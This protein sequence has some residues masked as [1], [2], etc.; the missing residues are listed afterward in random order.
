M[1]PGRP[2]LRALGV[3]LAGLALAPVSRAQVVPT[4]EGLKAAFVFRFAQFVEWPSAALDK[5][6]AVEYCVWRPNPFGRVLHELVA[7][8][9]LAGRPIVVREPAPSEPI[10][11]CHVLFVH[12][13]AVPAVLDRVGQ[14]PILTVGESPRFLD[15]GGIIQLIR[16]DN[17]LRF[18]VNLTAAERA[19]LRLSSHLL[20]LAASVRGGGA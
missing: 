13:A 20:R 2:Y 18:N 4:E 6:P 1:L 7:G 11:S 15:D 19:G 9:T 8:E 12:G 17:R 5:R 3:I 16:G 10:S 14:Q